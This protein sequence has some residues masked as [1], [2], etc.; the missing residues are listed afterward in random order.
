[1]FT[2]AQGNS[3]PQHHKTGTDADKHALKNYSEPR[4]P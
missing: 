1:M 4:V 3:E 2:V